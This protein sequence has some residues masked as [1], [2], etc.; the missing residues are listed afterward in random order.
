MNMSFG[1]A[2]GSNLKK[3]SWK[4]LP[5]RFNIYVIMIFLTVYL[6]YV[7]SIYVMYRCSIIFQG[8][9]NENDPNKEFGVL[10]SL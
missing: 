8:I 2:A 10:Q 9:C 5:K 7:A 1:K 4:H 3:S 6:S